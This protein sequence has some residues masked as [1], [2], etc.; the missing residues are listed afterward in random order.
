MEGGETSAEAV[1]AAPPPP[2]SRVLEAGSRSASESRDL[3]RESVVIAPLTGLME[4]LVS[5]ATPCQSVWS[6]KIPLQT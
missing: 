4:Y 6:S 5:E 3:R 2:P 1:A